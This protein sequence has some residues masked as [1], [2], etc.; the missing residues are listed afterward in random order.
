MYDA[1]RDYVV[2]DEK[3][4]TFADVMKDKNHYRI[5]NAGTQ[6]KSFTSET[7]IERLNAVLENNK[8]LSLSYICKSQILILSN[9]YLLIENNYFNRYNKNQEKN[10]QK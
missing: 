10:Q 6:T 5:T 2:S 9:C 8:R 3:I 7:S 4:F 1:R